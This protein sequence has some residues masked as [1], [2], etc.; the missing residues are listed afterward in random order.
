LPAKVVSD[1]GPPVAIDLKAAARNANISLTLLLAGG[2]AGIYHMTSHVIPFGSGFEMVAL[3]QNLV[4]HGSFGNPFAVLNTGPTAA[5]P[6]LYPFLLALII[7]V[8]RVPEIIAFAAT[9]GN[10]IANALTAN[11]IWRMSGLFSEDLRV[12]VVAAIFWILSSQLTPS[13][14]VGYT[15]A[16][17]LIFC[18]LTA[19]T[20]SR[21]RFLMSGIGAGLLAGAL[22]LFNPSTILISMPW[23][24]WL[25]YKHRASRK[26]TVLYC[27]LV[28]GVLCLTGATWGLRNQQQLGRFVIRTNLGM[29]LYASDNDCA[30]PSLVASEANN[31]YQ[32]HHPNTSIDEAQ[33]LKKLGEVNYDQVR[34]RD[35]EEWMRTHP[36]PL[37]RLMFA[38]V[39]DFWFPIPDGHPF[40]STVIWI[41]TVLSIPGLL[42][43]MRKRNEFRMFTGFVLL[44]YPMMYYIVVSDVRYRLPVLWLSLL[45]AATFVMSCW[46]LRSWWS[47]GLKTSN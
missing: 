2:A 45:P 31:C 26:Q 9:L 30:R 19:R 44:V 46:D 5:N 24:G 13:W 41:S 17:L 29:T 33:L 37:I 43:M 28:F 32:A 42:V 7:K 34:K 47:R 40:Q 22:F 39:R 6:P 12:G 20:I 16:T 38:R 15:V 1:Q 25:A 35:A 8:F 10:I 11:L 18:I 23:L 14:D 27:C 21:P 3:A 4:R 36:G